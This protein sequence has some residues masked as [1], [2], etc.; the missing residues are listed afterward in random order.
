VLW[1]HAGA[2]YPFLYGGAMAFFSSLL[3]AVV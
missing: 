1:E 2:A 3:L